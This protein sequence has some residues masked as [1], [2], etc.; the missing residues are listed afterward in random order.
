[1]ITRQRRLEFYL[2]TVNAVCADKNHIYYQGESMSL[3]QWCEQAIKDAVC[4]A[5]KMPAENI[6]LT[7]DEIKRSFNHVVKLFQEAQRQ[8][9]RDGSISVAEILSEKIDQYLSINW[10][11]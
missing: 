9:P 5:E 2:Q 7:K 4:F 6:V 10:G 8:Q 11:M 1:M 3:E